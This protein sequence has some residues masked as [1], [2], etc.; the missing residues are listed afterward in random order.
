MEEGGA[1]QHQ[2]TCYTNRD[3]RETKA[4]AAR[5]HMVATFSEEVVVT[6]IIEMYRKVL[7]DEKTETE[8]L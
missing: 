3:Y 2:L 5:Q 7:P 6:Q 8:R 4:T 1:L